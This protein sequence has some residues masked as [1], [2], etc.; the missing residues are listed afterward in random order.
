MHKE[1]EFKSMGDFIENHR[2]RVCAD[3]CGAELSSIWDKKLKREL[4][5]QG[6]PTVWSGRS[7]LLF[8]VV[9]KV[10]DD[11]YTY[12][13]QS[14]AMEKHGF[15]RHSQFLPVSQTP[16]EMAFILRQNEDTLRCYPFP[17]TLTVSYRLLDVGLQ[18][19]YDVENTGER[20]M[21]FSL[22]AHP[23]FNCA[24][25]DALVFPGQTRLIF[26]RLNRD[27]L[28]STAA[29]I[30]PLEGE[31]LA[32]SRD[33]FANDALIMRNIPFSQ[34][35]LVRQDGVRVRVDFAGAPCLGI[36]ARHG[37]PYVCIEP[38]HGLDDDRNAT[39]DLFDKPFIQTLAPGETFSWA[40]QI[41]SELEES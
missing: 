12:H 26:Y 18:I 19:R 27:M 5:W 10:K 21:P 30:L 24:L 14:Y 16:Q 41:T 3:C 32:I 40:M 23:G 8:P 15:A 6:D 1:R 33:L 34:V 17:F 28:L 37:A 38:W 29:D 7:P 9:G 13:C 25:G 20:L 36:W 4:L 39:G 2:Y 35:E 11:R 22:G 31:R